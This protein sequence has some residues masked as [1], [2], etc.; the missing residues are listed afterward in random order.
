MVPLPFAFMIGMLLGHFVEDGAG[1]VI[2]LELLAV[3]T[4]AILV[5]VLIRVAGERVEPENSVEVIISKKTIGSLFYALL[6]AT[7]FAALI[8]CPLAF[9]HANQALGLIDE[10]HVG[11]QYRNKAKLARAIAAIATLIWLAAIL[12]VASY[13]VAES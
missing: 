4:A 10:H 11:E 1:Y 9:V 7:G 12:C 13:Q 3:L 8:C 6:S 2:F 5:V